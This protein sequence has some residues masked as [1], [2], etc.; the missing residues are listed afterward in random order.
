MESFRAPGAVLFSEI[1]RK[2]NVGY[3]DGS[4]LGLVFQEKASGLLEYLHAMLEAGD[5]LSINLKDEGPLPVLGF[6]LGENEKILH[7]LRPRVT[8]DSRIGRT[9]CVPRRAEYFWPHY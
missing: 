9:T 8:H 7:R 2:G 5:S 1:Q 3:G 6:H 4:G